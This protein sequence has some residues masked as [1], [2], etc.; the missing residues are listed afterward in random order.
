MVP[1]PKG[2]Q[3]N[4]FQLRNGCPSKLDC[5]TKD[6]MMIQS[7]TFDAGCHAKL[8][9]S[10]DLSF[11]QL[12]SLVIGLTQIRTKGCPRSRFSKVVKIHLNVLF[13][14]LLSVGDYKRFAQ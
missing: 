13:S 3:W 14:D 4:L 6:Y 7:G 11:C 8:S 5:Y 12:S 1:I 9:D 10:L 2:G